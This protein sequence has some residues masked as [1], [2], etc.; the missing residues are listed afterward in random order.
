MKKLTAGEIIDRLGMKPLPIEGGY[1][2]VNYRSEDTLRTDALPS[3]SVR[4][5]LG[6]YQ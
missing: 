6:L 5:G 4:T 1:Y 3:E 2:A